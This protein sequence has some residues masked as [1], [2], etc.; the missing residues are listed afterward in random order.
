[1]KFTVKVKVHIGL[2]S[3]FTQ[4]RKKRKREELF[5]QKYENQTETYEKQKEST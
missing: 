3:N 2:V 1:V 5:N 4:M